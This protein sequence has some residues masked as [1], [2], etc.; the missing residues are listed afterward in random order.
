MRSTFLRLLALAFALVQPACSDDRAS[1]GDDGPS[2]TLPC[3]S[4]GS[5]SGTC[6]PA[7]DGYCQ[8]RELEIGACAGSCAGASR[9]VEACC[10]QIGQPGKSKDNPYLVRTTNT[11]EYSGTGAPNLSCF[12]PGSYPKKP[13]AGAPLTV[14]LQGVVKP[15]S[16]GGCNEQHLIG[17]KADRSDA[18]RIEI[19]TVK[20]T[21]DPETDGL[22]DQLVG[23]PLVLS[24]DNGIEEED[25]TSCSGDPR[26][27]RKYSYAGV[28]LYTELIVKTS[29]A[30]LSWRPLYAYVYFTETDSDAA[31][32]PA[33]SA[34][35][36]TYAYDARALEG[37]DFNVIPQAA[38]GKTMAPGNGAV[39]GEVHD[40]DNIRLQFARVDVTAPRYDVTY[41]ND[42]Q[43]KPRPDA[44]R[45]DVGTGATSIYSALD[46]TVTGEST[47]ARVAGTGLV[48]DGDKAKLVGL[49]Y[50]DVR[51]FK[52]SVTSVTLRGLRPFQVP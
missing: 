27:N 7:N 1:S 11:K 46:V 3:N 33:F 50:H 26:Y 37:S 42:D 25:V 34:A 6:R 40:C 18:V 36:G 21:S 9:P 48:P 12:E 14:T 17:T 23:T 4:P 45:R 28:P 22:P 10:V 52:N 47:F 19:H 13:P 20:R 16:N 51:V 43:D 24:S 29:S 38:I 41:Y 49:G 30:D 2:T 44:S 8:G 31:G 32:D 15:F 5:C 35:A 39:G